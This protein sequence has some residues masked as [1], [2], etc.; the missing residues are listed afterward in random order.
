MRKQK[1]NNAPPLLK[2]I[3][4]NNSIIPFSFPSKLKNN[5]IPCFP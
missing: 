4:H 5:A 3:Q 2:Y 1:K